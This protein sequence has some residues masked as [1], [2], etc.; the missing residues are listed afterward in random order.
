MSGFT[1][2][3]KKRS[4]K[5]WL[6]AGGAVLGLALAVSIVA[7]TAF[8]GTIDTFLGGLNPIFDNSVEKVFKTSYEN[9]DD[10]L[11][12]SAKLNK[13][14]EQE[15]S[16]LLLNENKALPLASGAKISVLGKNSA[17]I[18][19]SG[20][21][22]GDAGSAG[23]ISLYQGLENGGF[24]LNP[25]LKEFYQGSASGA[26]RSSNPQLTE[27]ST[28]APT[29]DIGETPA[30]SYSRTLK[31]SFKEYGDAAIVVISRIGGESFDLP[32]S[33][34]VDNGG[35]EGNHYL[36]LDQNEYDL[37]DMATSNFKKVIV[38]LNTLTSFQCDFI[39]EYNNLESDPRIDAVLW[40]GGPGVN[41][42]DGIAGVLN[43][44]VN[45]SGKTVDVFSRDFTKDPTWK[46]FGDN[47]Q[48]FD[49]ISSAAFTENGENVANNFMVT[50]EEGVYTGYRYYETRGYEEY[51]K[52]GDYSWYDEAV[53][54]PFGH[55]LSYTTFSQTISSSGSLATG[56]DVKITVTNTGDV[57]GKG[58]AELYVTLPYT[59]GG[60]E[61]SRVQLLDFAKTPLLEKG[62][63]H[64][65][66][67]HVDPYDLASY[68][69]ND[70]NG[71][72]F[73]GYETEAGDY[74]F[75][76]GKDSHV[77]ETAYGKVTLNLAEGKKYDKDPVTGTVVENR[78]TTD[79]FDDIQYRL[80]DVYVE[81]ED[82]NEYVRKGMSR[83]NFEKTFPAAPDVDERDYL[84]GEKEYL[85][86]KTHNNPIADA[87][88]EMPKTAQEV[89]HVLRDL[90][91]K[92]YNDAMWGELLDSLTYEDMIN[93][94]NYGDFKTQPIL[95]IEKN[96]TNDSDGPVGFV[97]FMPGLASHYKNNPT[98]ASEIVIASTWNKDLAYKMGQMVGES[99]V[100]GDVGGNG[101]PY[102]GWYAPAVNLH[103]SPFS[104]RN[105]E[106]YS[107]DPILS[108]KMAVNVINGAYTKGVVSDL[109]HFALNDQET[110]RSGVATYCTE[111]ALRELYLK[112]F[113]LAVKGSDNPVYSATATSDKT[114]FV[115][116]KGIMSSFNRI[117]A[118]WTGGDYRLLTEILRNEWGYDGL[119]I[120][121][122]KTD[123]TV[124][125]SRQMLYAG[126][127]L[128]LTTLDTLRWNDSDASSAKDVYVL[129]TAAHNILYTVANSNSVNVR[130]I[131]Y[132]LETWVTAF[133]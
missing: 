79:D 13:E 81:D 106:Y 132:N 125:D 2:F 27:G 59:K 82:G 133:I 80:A 128:I 115:G 56:V 64:E 76:A 1:K 30:S 31:N 107:E 43:G 108:G 124:M 63:S 5:A 47:S 109:K 38:M 57:A 51:L 46:N 34:N 62:K 95:S 39:K 10:L 42:A 71:N 53:V 68:D 130:I 15:G 9:K 21:G 118:K 78:Y 40:I 24:V 117:G 92:D 103:R 14:I 98:F 45:P 94:V 113:E 120:C 111:Q 121:D 91:G 126:N 97:N 127:D 110:N 87:V 85:A 75:Y 90:Y 83:T 89:K 67:F 105:Y 16:V 49:G 60:I 84:E 20:S 26:G 35:I 129:R 119:V 50:Y 44:E 17:N 54:F 41:G 22:S 123:N 32:R 104:G 3:L 4:G 93:L 18:V 102:T 112:P 48:N 74:T 19:L 61:K 131:G 7:T 69:Y 73:K 52:G 70:A 86:D 12:D 65:F 116:T 101:L 100:L 96:L 29:L 28:K 36:Q 6:I 37:L 25:S 23:A 88:T 122:Y 66:T 58:V 55:G 114:T 8:R 99:G 77:D 11:A 33:Q 72:S